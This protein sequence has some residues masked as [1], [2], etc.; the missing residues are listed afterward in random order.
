MSSFHTLFH[1]VLFDIFLLVS[2]LQYIIFNVP[3]LHCIYTV[4]HTRH[5]QYKTSTIQNQSRFTHR[6]WTR[7]VRG[8]LP[9]HCL[10]NPLHLPCDALHTSLLAGQPMMHLLPQTRHVGDR[11]R[12][13]NSGL[14]RTNHAA[15]RLRWTASLASILP[16]KWLA[17]DLRRT[18][19]VDGYS[20]LESELVVVVLDHTGVCHTHRQEHTYHS[21]DHGLA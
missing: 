11:R 1:E 5:A 2:F 16:V 4:S 20:A 10:W 17:Y 8:W 19:S 13:S 14:G 12:P 21:R 3:L 15:P 7:C 6:N 18:A 9:F